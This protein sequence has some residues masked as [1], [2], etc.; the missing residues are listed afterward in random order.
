MLAADASNDGTMLGHDVVEWDRGDM[1]A[2]GSYGTKMDGQGRRRNGLWDARRRRVKDQM[3]LSDS[4][5]WV[6]RTVRT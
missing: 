1:F 4:K 6:S 3:V 5:F 2:T